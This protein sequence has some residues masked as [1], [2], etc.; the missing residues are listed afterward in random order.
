LLLSTEASKASAP[1]PIL[2]PP[3]APPLPPPASSAVATFYGPQFSRPATKALVPSRLNS[4]LV[5][6]A[7][8]LAMLNFADCAN[9]A[10]TAGSNGFAGRML[11]NEKEQSTDSAGTDVG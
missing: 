1:L 4:G 8:I 6:A 11:Y 2:N 3:P 10:A 5:T 7:L 9:P